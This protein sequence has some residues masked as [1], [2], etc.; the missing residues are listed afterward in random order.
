MFREFVASSRLT[1]LGQTPPPGSGLTPTPLLGPLSFDWSCDA[2]GLYVSENF[3]SPP[4]WPSPTDTPFTQGTFRWLF[5]RDHPLSSGDTSSL[6]PLSACWCHVTKKHPQHPPPQ[7]KT[8]GKFAAKEGILFLVSVVLLWGRNSVSSV[9]G[10]VVVFIVWRPRP[11]G[12]IPPLWAR[13]PPSFMWPITWRVGCFLTMHCRQTS[14]NM[15]CLEVK[16]GKNSVPGRCQ[17]HAEQIQLLAPETETGV[18]GLNAPPPVFGCPANFKQKGGGPG[19]RLR[20]PPGRHIGFLMRSA[21]WQGWAIQAQGP[22]G[23]PNTY[24]LYVGLFNEIF[25]KSLENYSWSFFMYRETTIKL[26][27]LGSI[28]SR[29]AWPRKILGENFFE[30]SGWHK[31]SRNA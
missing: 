1:P 29:V 6:A 18:K 30:H 23:P 16:R 5:T 13:P 14:F 9:C 26:E 24:M 4:P 20:Q 31:K 7:K 28:V 8:S 17:K 19:L 15:M 3:S 2:L 22:G 10:V 27:M 11:P 21:K 25:T 12:W